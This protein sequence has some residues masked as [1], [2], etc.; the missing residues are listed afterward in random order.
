MGNQG[1]LGFHDPRRRF[2]VLPPDPRIHFTLNCGASSCPPI[3]T[4]SEA[5]L[6]EGLAGAAA[7]YLT[8]ETKIDEEKKTVWLS[9][10]FKFFS[11]DFGGSKGAILRSAA[12]FLEGEPQKK[13]NKLIEEAG[14]DKINLKYLPYDWSLNQ[15]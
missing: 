6:E 13:L 3:S 14:T 11:P 15:A 8:G 1:P 5:N 10:L 7:A 12:S 2:V 4:Y 9:K